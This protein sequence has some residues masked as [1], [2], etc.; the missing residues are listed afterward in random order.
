M[1]EEEKSEK[2]VK[3]EKPEPE[4]AEK[5]AKPEKAQA[6]EEKPASDSA[7][8][9]LGKKISQMTLQEVEAEL[10]I[11]KEKMGGFQSAHARHLLAR[12][13]ELVH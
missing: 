1:P 2:P 13:K 9:E 11:V 6:K 10:K 8:K 7:K 4:K 5:A 12:K 3:A